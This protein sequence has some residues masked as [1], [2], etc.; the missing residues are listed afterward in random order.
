M[1][2]CFFVCWTENNWASLFRF[3]FSL[4]PFTS[5]QWS[6]HQ[7]GHYRKYTFRRFDRHYPPFWYEVFRTEA[8]IF[9][10]VV[11]KAVIVSV[12]EDK[13]IDLY[14]CIIYKHVIKNI[15]WFL[16]SLFLY[17]KKISIWRMRS[18]FRSKLLIWKSKSTWDPQLKLKHFKWCIFYVVSCMF[19]LTMSS[20]NH[21]ITCRHINL[22]LDLSSILDIVFLLKKKSNEPSDIDVTPSWHMY[23]FR[24]LAWANIYFEI[25][26]ALRK[27]WCSF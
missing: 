21:P 5:V 2:E 10:V 20:G 9:F 27:C 24:K 23:A 26:M 13:L 11:R 14:F 3:C 18:Q 25:H 4:Q 6:R 1:S 15:H 19:C 7:K 16:S 8:A 17:F 12:G 22:D